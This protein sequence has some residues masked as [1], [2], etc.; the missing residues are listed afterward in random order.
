MMGWSFN[1][2]ICKTDYLMFT[3][4]LFIATVLRARLGSS[5]AFTAENKA[6]KALLQ[7]TFPQRVTGK[8]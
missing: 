8:T 2:L 7:P 4:Q 3:Q 1:L 6:N 5:P